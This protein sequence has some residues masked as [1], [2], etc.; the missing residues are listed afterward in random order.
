MTAPGFSA[1]SASDPLS[2][3]TTPGGLGSVEMEL[4]AQADRGVMRGRPG[5]GPGSGHRRVW[6]GLAT[7]MF[8]A[9]AVSL[10][11]SLLTP[12]WE[13]NDEPEHVQ[14]IEYVMH[15]GRVPAISVANGWESGQPPLYYYLAAE[16]QRL[17]DIPHFRVIP[18]PP[19]L[20]TANPVHLLMR[21]DYTAAERE[22]AIWVHELRLMS[23]LLAGVTVGACY[24]ATWLVSGRVSLATGS[25]L[26]A[27][28]LPKFGV[29]FG[30]V[31]ND[32][33][34]DALCGLALVAVLMWLRVG[35]GGVAR[36]LA[37]SVAVGL[38]LGCATL[39][40]LTALPVAVFVFGL[41]LLGTL[42]RRRR[43]WEPLT[44]LALAAAVSG[45]FYLR[46]YLVY[47]DFLAARA[48]E[49][50]VRHFFPGCLNISCYPLADLHHWLVG[51]PKG[52]VQT[53]WY[54]GGWNQLTLYPKVS[55]LLFLAAILAVAAGAWLGRDLWAGPDGSLLR[56]SL[57]SMVMVVLGGL[58]AAYS[59]ALAATQYQGR[60]TF[61][62]IGGITGLITLGTWAVLRRLGV[63]HEWLA[64][65]VWPV[66]MAGLL[67]AV[68]FVYVI[69]L[70][71]L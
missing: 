2:S 55:Y 70:R 9:L 17:L 4:R 43:Q 25:A 14:Y 60:Y 28:L 67:G 66:L 33:L 24:L 38:L 15:T 16:W 68:T 71:G 49:K 47:G 48:N 19:A 39:T 64:A 51:V 32:T 1:G 45:W 40:K 7:S 57:S 65:M 23:V 36:R 10:A 62:G 30:A 13:A 31:T 61:V 69:P 56:W 29:V 12:A 35:S 5:R 26:F 34:V 22:Q 20:P 3:P 50:M 44:M 27:A 37:W 58:G 46:N 53:L 21:H 63:R 11:F 54:V 41:I 8:V 42:R 59:V 6:L 52:I 18:L